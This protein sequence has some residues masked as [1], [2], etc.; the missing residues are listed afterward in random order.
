[1]NSDLIIDE[2]TKLVTKLRAREQ[3]ALWR[4]SEAQEQVHKIREQ[5]RAVETTMSLCRQATAPDAGH[6]SLVTE[7]REAKAKGKTQLE[8][9][10]II[11]VR[12]NG[13]LKAVDAQRLMVE[14]GLIGRPKNAL[15]ILYTL[16]ARSGDK[17]SKVKPGEYQLSREQKTDNEEEGHTPGSSI[18]GKADKAI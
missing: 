6:G 14:A 15:S 3:E 7:L 9:L 4:F 16:I 1:M 12:N 2:L 11:A 18:R 13:R 8:A 5:L 10:E 17:F